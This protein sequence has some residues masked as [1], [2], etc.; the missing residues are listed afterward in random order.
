MLSKSKKPEMSVIGGCLRG[1]NSYLVNFSQSVAE[2]SEF[3]QDIYKFA[4]MAVDPKVS[5]SRYEVPRGEW[6]ASSFLTRNKIFI[7]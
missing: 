3:A 7:V 1:L 6:R 5:H 2:G 4:R